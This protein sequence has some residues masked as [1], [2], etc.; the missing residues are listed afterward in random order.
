MIPNERGLEIKVGLF[1]LL[2]LL[3]AGG[4]IVQFGRIGEGWHENYYIEVKFPDA[5]GLY[6][7]A[8]VLMSGAKVGRVADHPSLIPGEDG[9]IT[10]LRIL[11]EIKIPKGSEFRVGSSGLLGDRFIQIQRIPDQETSEMLSPGSTVVGRREAGLDDFTRDAEEI[12]S[13]AK[14][15]LATLQSASTKFDTD[16]L[17]E[18]NLE[19][20]R[21]LLAGAGKTATEIAEATERLDSIFKQA[22]VAMEALGSAAR[23]IEQLALDARQGRGILSAVINDD[24]LSRDLRQFIANIRARGILFYRDR[25]ADEGPAPRGRSR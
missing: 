10:R 19:N 14:E 6:K 4:L 20:T 24:Q 1:L 18:E 25:P 3:V 17:S 16:L 12:V 23:N 21:L 2:G 11:N 9:V 13:K 22:T 15:L 7:G 8:E 5:S